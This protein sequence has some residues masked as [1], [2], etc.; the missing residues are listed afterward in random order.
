ML[1]IADPLAHGRGSLL[2]HVLQTILEPSLDTEVEREHQRAR[3]SRLPNTLIP[4]GGSAPNREGGIA[5]AIGTSRRCALRGPLPGQPMA[6]ALDS[7][8]TVWCPQLAKLT[9]RVPCL[10]GLAGA[11]FA[12]MAIDIKNLSPDVERYI[13][14]LVREGVYASP[15]E[16]LEHAVRRLR[17]GDEERHDRLLKA[18]AEGEEGEGTRYA[19]G[20]MNELEEAAL[21]DMW[22]GAPMDPDVVGD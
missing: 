1:L 9:P 3:D 22:S 13:A 15:E 14:A 7:C 19:R 8:G 6:Q 21:K 10:W 20:L 4:M 16:M 11:I 2:I 12:P 17:Q 5:S 18:L